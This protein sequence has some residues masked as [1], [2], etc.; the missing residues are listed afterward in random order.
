VENGL[1]G[2]IFGVSTE[3][4]VLPRSELLQSSTTARPFMCVGSRE[5]PPPRQF[6]R[7]VVA[8]TS[9]PSASRNERAAGGAAVAPVP[10]IT[11]RAV[12]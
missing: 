1:G 11:S 10:E 6:L 9:R 7:P 8:R 2:W 12:I 4:H 3:G 5:R